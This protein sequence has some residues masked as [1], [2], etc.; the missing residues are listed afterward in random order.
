MNIHV[1]ANEKF[2]KMFIELISSKY[3]SEDNIVYVYNCEENVNY[4]NS[5]NIQYIDDLNQ[6]KLNL[7]NGNGKLFIHAFYKKYISKVC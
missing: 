1:I 4:K 6:V 2:T 5:K 7:L 3:N